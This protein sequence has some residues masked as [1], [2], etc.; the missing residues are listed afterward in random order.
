MT[1]KYI[2]LKNFHL[3]VGNGTTQKRF[4]CKIGT[5]RKHIKKQLKN[6]F[7]IMVNNLTYAASQPIDLTNLPA[8]S[9]MSRDIKKL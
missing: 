7:I 5:P 2:L 4:P 8:D 6:L 3:L 1:E 9:F